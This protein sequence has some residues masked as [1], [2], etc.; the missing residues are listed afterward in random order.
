MNERILVVDD[1]M[2]LRVLLKEALKQEG[3]TEVVT[4]ANLSEAWDQFILIEPDLIIL[5]IMLPDGNGLDFCAK[6]RGHSTVPILF[7]SA[8]S[9]EVDKLLALSLG[10]DDYV[11]KPFSPKE[12]V[13][14]VKSQLRRAG[15]YAKQDTARSGESRILKAGPFTMNEDETEMYLHDQPLDLT[16]KEAGL[17]ACFIRRQGQIISQE[18]LYETV[19]NESY[20]GA[21]NTL[22]VHIRRLREKVEENPSSPVL[23]KTVKGLGYRLNVKK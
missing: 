3:Y 9:D 4:A 19:W 18:T 2:D 8:K 12:V 13:Y 1:E 22:M 20:F 5:D 23:I 17:L 11:T 10:G 6:I 21:A 14:R 15:T 7:L 16:A